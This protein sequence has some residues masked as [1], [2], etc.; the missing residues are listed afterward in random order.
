MSNDI[1]KAD[2]I[3]HRF[4]TKL[5]L[6]VSNARTTAEP[7]SQGKPDKWFNLETPDLDLFKDH[8]RIYRAVSSSPTPPPFE[9]QVLLSIPES[10]TNQVLVYLAPD[11]SRIRIDPIPRYILLENWLLSFTPG[12]S[13]THHNDEPGDVAPSTIY[14]HGIPLFRSLF[15]LL[16]ILPSWKLFMKLRRRM[17]TPYRNGNLS[18]QLRIKGFDDGLSDILNFGKSHTLRFKPQKPRGAHVRFCALAFPIRMTW[19]NAL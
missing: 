9:L 3:A 11:S 7:R 6:V 8:L 19:H 2:Q 16:R 14:K 5:C 10:T 1:Q 17:S 15:S 4:Y 13:Q 18:I 12:F